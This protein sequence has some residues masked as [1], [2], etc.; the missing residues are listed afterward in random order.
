LNYGCHLQEFSVL[1]I[2]KRFKVHEMNNLI[3]FLN[4]VPGVAGT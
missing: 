2:V 3:F 4:I 1:K